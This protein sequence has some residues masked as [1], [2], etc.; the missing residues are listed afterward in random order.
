MYQVPVNNLARIRRARKQVKKALGDI[1]LEFCKEAAEE[2]KEFSPDEQVVKSSLCLD[3]CGWDPSYS[4]S[5]EYRSKPFCCTECQFSSKFYSG[6]KNHFRNVHRNIFDGKILLNCPY[7]AFTA[8]KRTLEIHVKIF[9]MPNSSRQNH[10]NALGTMLRNNAIFNVDKARQGDAV[11]KAMYFCKK[12]S[13]RD[14]LYN[15]VK[16]HIYKEHFQHIVS[17]YI[18]VVS[19][20]GKK[21]VSSVSGG[22][23]H[24][25]RCQ[26]ITSTY[27]GLVQH[28]IEYHECIGAQ[29]TSMIGHATV[30]VSKPPSS[31]AMSQR[32]PLVVNRVRPPSQPVIGY[33]KPGAPA[34][35]KQASLSPSQISVSVPGNNVV[36]DNSVTGVHT[37]QTQ[38]WKICTVCNELFPE[39]LY[40]AHFENAH[41]AKKVWAM[42]KY[43]MKIHNFTSKCLLCNRY[44]PTDTLLNH[45]LIHG[46]TCPQCHSAFHNVQKMME[47]VAQVHPHDYVG[48]PGAVPLTFDLTIKQEKTVN[49]QLAIIPFN[50]KET[51]NGQDQSV[52]TQNSIPALTQLPSLKMTE[53]RSEPLIG[54]IS[55]IT[56]NSEVGKTICPLC[57]TILKGPVAEALSRHLRER[58]QVLQTMHPVEKK[59]T[60]KCIHCLGVYTSNMVA[61]TIT[62][63]LVQCRAVGR[64]QYSRAPQSSLILNSSGVGFLKRQPAVQDASNAKKVKLGRESKNPASSSGK[65]GEPEGLAMDPR[66]YEHK[67][68]EARKNFLSAYFNRRPYITSEEAEKLSASLWLWKSDIANHFESKQKL[69]VKACETRKVAVLLGFDMFAVRQVKHNLTFEE[70]KTDDTMVQ[71]SIGSGSALSKTKSK[72]RKKQNSTLKP[73]TCT[74]T[75]CIDSDSEPNAEE[76]PTENGNAGQDKVGDERPE[77]TSEQTC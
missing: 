43:I 64:N 23:I 7:C 40:S 17:P 4:K 60:Y 75:I 2:F 27:E 53:M 62:L 76:S 37:A 26:F 69:C 3:I 77:S 50:M 10:G 30:Y 59:M 5:Q 21:A 44:L 29:V 72:Q 14:T 52:T 12:C 48:P 41:K 49:V 42:A 57:F 65:K 33:L 36:A 38:K 9:H 20:S 68:Y 11:A 51:V 35:T 16:K 55:P 1:G 56:Q 28:V 74:E 58:H 24:C 66:S 18:G 71:R 39:N 54:G 61:S 6:Y 45:M 22:N 63:H 8:S 19:E 32:A 73:N 47:H 15:V 31:P 46:L 67:T 34:I 70:A 13:F 25:K